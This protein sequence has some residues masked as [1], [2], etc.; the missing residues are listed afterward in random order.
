MTYY[1]DYYYQPF[2]LPTEYQSVSD[3]HVRVEGY[4]EE[5]ELVDVWTQS[6]FFE[7]VEHA[8]AQSYSDYKER[9]QSFIQTFIV[10]PL[11]HEGYDAGDDRG[12]GEEIPPSLESDQVCE[13]EDCQG[14]EGRQGYEVV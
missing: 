9:S 10:E 4:L 14:A 2:Y 8:E 7:H 6:H 5:D 3:H 12:Q 13:V 11:T 1:H